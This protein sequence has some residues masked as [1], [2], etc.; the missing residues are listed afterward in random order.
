MKTISF[1]KISNDFIKN[2]FEWVVS[3]YL[4]NFICIQFSKKL[5]TLIVSKKFIINF[6]L[7]TKIIFTYCKLM[8]SYLKRG[9]NYCIPIYWSRRNFLYGFFTSIQRIFPRYIWYP[10]LWL[11]VID[12][13]SW[14]FLNCYYSWEVVI[15]VEWLLF[16][17]KN[18]LT[19]VG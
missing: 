7:G 17:W 19:L 13:R 2:N 11:N 5:F 10:L 12:C 4:L 14:L 1:P 6:N 3:I 18:L 9:L 16:L 8:D 15:I